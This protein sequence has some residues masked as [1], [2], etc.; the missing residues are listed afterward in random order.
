MQTWL[1]VF[2]WL[3]LAG[4]LFVT[5]APIGLRPISL[6]PTQLERILALV[7]I[8]FCFAFAYPRH[9]VP[10]AVLVF[11]AIVGAELLQLF[12][13][14][15]HGRVPDAI[16]KLAGAAAGLVAGHLLNRVRHR[17]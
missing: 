6:L 7:I 2:A 11:G 3:L 4:L 5:L 14:S 12:A 13:P 9:T 15:R 16:A 17:N 10:V 1:R 8:G